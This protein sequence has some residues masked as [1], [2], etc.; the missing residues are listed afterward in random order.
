MS[1]KLIA[2]LVSSTMMFAN[3]S[4]SAWSAAGAAQTVNAGGAQIAASETKNVP[5]LAPA[6]AAGIREAQGAGNA[7]WIVGGFI[8][9]YVLLVLL[10]GLG[11]DDDDDAPTGT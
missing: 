8:A 5:P 9:V 4:T 3:I 11:D 1:R 10:D 2:V 7:G 6:G